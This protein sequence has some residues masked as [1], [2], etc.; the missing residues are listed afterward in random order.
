MMNKT[1]H[2]SYLTKEQVLDIK[3]ALKIMPIRKVAKVF[4]FSESKI[5]NIYLGITYRNVS[6][7]E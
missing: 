6:E 2:Y 1:Y 5:R 7:N 3:K 4:N